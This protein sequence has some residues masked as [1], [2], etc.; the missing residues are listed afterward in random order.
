MFVV[1]YGAFNEGEIMVKAME[2]GVVD[3][4]YKPLRPSE[5]SR[6][7]QTVLRRARDIEDS[8]REEEDFSK[9]YDE[10][11]Y[12][13]KEM[14]LSNLL[15]GSIANDAEIHRSFDYFKMPFSK[16]FTVFVI[17]I[18]QFKKV[19]LT[20]DE[21]EKHLLSFKICFFASEAMKGQQCETAIVRF[22]Q[23]AVLVGGFENLD[24]LIELC[25]KMKEEIY[26]RM[27]IRVT[28]GIGRTYENP[29]DISVSCREAES[30]LRYRFHVG[31][32]TVV[33]IHYMEPTNVITYR[34]PF[35]LEDRLVF[36]AVI[37]E[38]KYCRILLEEI[39]NS[40]SGVGTLPDK[41]LSKLVMNIIISI[42]R[43][44]SEQNIPLQSPFTTFFPSKEVLEIDDIGQ[45]FEY[46]DKALKSFCGFILE[47]HES[48]NAKLVADAKKIC[49]EK[50]YESFSINKIAATLGTTP[51]Y[52][53][54]L[55]L[56]REKKP[57][58]DYAVRVRLNEAK[59]LM[60]ETD[61]S[62]DMVAV[63]VGY[64]DGRHFR[65]VFRKYEG[66]NTTD[67]RAQYNAL[68]SRMISTRRGL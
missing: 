30:A 16:G 29:S 27:K 12:L 57:L 65:S 18:D 41:F 35:D 53:N 66:V 43:Y 55:F 10:K 49:D 22:N 42:N 68:S 56:D 24:K 14:F 28:I 5:V 19:M 47:Y 8:R 17:R 9:H 61:L 7:M 38:Y 1:L 50:Y 11:V 45:A 63:K 13:F 60:R 3:Y 67:Y 20:L 4:M 25:E 64:D 32:N 40:L 6:C 31:Y 62:D 52:L 37:G 21:K 51:E 58:L 2:F 23:V 44:L 34:Y 39:F 36:T 48:L 33:P 59:K 54:R 15:C 26:S 46:L